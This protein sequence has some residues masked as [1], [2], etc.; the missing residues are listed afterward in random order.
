MV[1]VVVVV[2]V[3]V[4]VEVEVVPKLVTLSVVALD[5][6]AFSFSISVWRCSLNLMI[7]AA[8]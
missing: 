1:V 6:L 4:K 8:L 5:G 7:L 3:G 2:E